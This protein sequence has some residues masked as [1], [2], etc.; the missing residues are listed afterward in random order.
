MSNGK[1][2]SIVVVEE[3]GRIAG[4]DKERE[5]MQD[6]SKID[7]GR[8]EF[9]AALAVGTVGAVY[10]D[11][12]PPLMKGLSRGDAY[13]L[14]PG[15]DGL[16]VRV[17]PYFD[18]GW[19]MYMFADRCNNVMLSTLFKSPS[20]KIVMIDGGWPKDADFLVPALKELGGM[21]DAWFLTH[22]HM[23]HYGALSDI[24]A[25]P[26]QEGLT[27]KRVVHKFLP[28]DFIAETE[29]SCYPFVTAFLNNL[30]NSGIIVETPKVGQEWDFGEGLSFECLNDYDL[31]MKSNSINNSSICYRVMN[32]GKSIIVTGD[33]GWQ[34]GDKLLKTVPKEK[35]KSD[36]LFLSHHG[37]M[38]ANK[39]FYEA[40]N[41]E[42]CVWPTPQW[43]WD[44]DHGGKGY[45]SG[46]W[47][48]NYVKCWMQ[49]IGVK[50]QIL[51]TKD[52]ALGPKNLPAVS[53]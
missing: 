45:G 51:L 5:N 2:F 24:L 39:N 44:N 29:K 49:D 25:R 12:I 3:W 47:L 6:S 40:V 7:F 48:T 52:A 35:I 36:I 41:P 42:I 32:G 27:I 10:G 31:T 18:G 20:G 37:Q 28:P 46:K 26:E 14:A 43:L 34:M 11:A 22:A 23:D 17:T 13:N 53:A 15:R 33:I 4:N 21:V 8:R 38:G 9:L 19:T 50:R 16:K 30:G 1:G